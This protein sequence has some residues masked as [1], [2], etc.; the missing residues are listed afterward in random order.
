M[1]VFERENFC[2]GHKDKILVEGSFICF[3]DASF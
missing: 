1:Y 2:E 3:L